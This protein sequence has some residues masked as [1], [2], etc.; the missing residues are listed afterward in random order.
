MGGNRTVR[1]YASTLI[2]RK[3]GSIVG[4]C[5][6]GMATSAVDAFYPAV[7]ELSALDGTNGFALSGIAAGDRSGSSVAAA[8]DVNGDGV[9]DFLIGAPSVAVDE[10]PGAGQS[11]VIFGTTQG[12]PAA[13]ELA[14]LDGTNGFALNGIAA[15]DRFGASVAA[16]GDVNG[17]GVADFL[18][19]AP[20]ATPNN[21]AF[22]GQS[23]VIFG[24]TQ[25]FPAAVELAALDGTNGF[26]LKGINSPD[27]SGM[28]VSAAG[29][30]NGDGIDDLLVGAPPLLFSI[31]GLAGQ[32]YVIFG[33]T[34][35]FPAAV[36]LAALDGTNGFA[37]NGIAAGDASGTSVAAAGDI[38]G[39]G[40]GDLLIGAPA[41][42]PNGTGCG[43]ELRHLRGYPRRAGHLGVGHVR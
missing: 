16:A 8:G 35:G 9:A 11:Y 14:A 43:P 12:F 3:I 33:T 41:A 2:R 28:S 4:L 24:T 30:V 37:L 18:I 38:N 22:A 34:Q 17:D 7:L 32:S 21:R 27:L 39:D 29:D 13:V 5:V 1:R 20:F 6:F 40:V 42:A 15:G 19:G 26:I 10:K 23:Y 31:T 25:G 36:E